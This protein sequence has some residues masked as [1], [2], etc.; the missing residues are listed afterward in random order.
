MA[1]SPDSLLPEATPPSPVFGIG[2]DAL[3]DKV[4]FPQLSE[5]ELAE[6]ALFGERRSFAKSELLFCVG[7]YPFNSHA[8]LSGTIRIVDVSTGERVVFVRYGAGY[9]TGDIDLFTRRPSVEDYSCL[10]ASIGFIFV[11]RRPGR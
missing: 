1:S 4:A 10:S 11:A 7:D 3:A 5:A 8:I 9:F 6:V 2:P